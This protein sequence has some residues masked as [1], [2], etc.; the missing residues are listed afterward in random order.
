V[1]ILLLISSPAPPVSMVPP[2]SRRW[3]RTRVGAGEMGAGADTDSLLLPGNQPRPHPAQQLASKESRGDSKGIRLLPL[4][5]CP[6][7][8]REVPTMAPFPVG[9][10]DSLP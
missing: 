5:R 1:S 4:E 9:Q 2:W 3:R 7:P 6:V 10:G 8:L